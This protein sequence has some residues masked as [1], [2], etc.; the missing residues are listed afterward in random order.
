VD[1]DAWLR[2]F[3]PD[4]I[5]TLYVI[6]AQEYFLTRRVVERIKEA[7]RDDIQGDTN[8]Q[9]LDGAELALPELL[10]A[11]NTIPFFGSRRLVVLEEAARF[12]DRLGKKEAQTLLDYLSSP[13]ATATLVMIFDATDRRRWRD[14]YS[15]WAKSIKGHGDFV[16]CKPVYEEQIPGWVRRMAGYR[17]IKLD[18]EAVEYLSWR[19][20]AD[21]QTIYSELEKLEIYAQGGRT[22]TLKDIQDLVGD[23]RQSDIFVFQHH[24]GGGDLAAALLMLDKLLSEGEEG[25]A[26]LNR[27]FYYFKQLL[28][29]KELDERGEASSGTVA[30]ITNNRS[31]KIN[32]QFIEESRR[33]S[34]GELLGVF[35]RLLEADRLMKTG[36]G[37]EH[38]ILPALVAELCGGG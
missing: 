23:R 25:I 6:A 34:K 33:F 27:M 35:P 8:Y 31:E 36:G 10:E 22:L 5:K 13:C 38:D 2:S 29:I 21:L 1:F 24:L 14:R 16:E 3:K 26:I 30:R 7:L 15:R 18:A 17:G 9:R 37:R 20:G 19:L 32:R 11:V 28:R 4:G 12:V